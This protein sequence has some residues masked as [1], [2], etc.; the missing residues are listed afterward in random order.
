M[1]S[2]LEMDDVHRLYEVGCHFIMYGQQAEL[3]VCNVLKANL[4]N[5]KE[6]TRL[7]CGSF[8]KIASGWVEGTLSLSLP[9]PSLSRKPGGFF[10]SFE[11]NFLYSFFKCLGNAT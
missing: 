1:I 5:S 11:S 8:I 4:Y 10:Y 6:L 2:D 9:P 3:V 7:T